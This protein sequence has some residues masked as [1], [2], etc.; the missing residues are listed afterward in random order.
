[1]YKSLGGLKE[2][3][4]NHMLEI[5][6]KIMLGIY[7]MILFYLTLAGRKQVDPLIN[8]FGG[9]LPFKRSNQTWNIDA[10]Y[11]I[12][13]LTPLT[14]F[15]GKSFPHITKKNLFKK[16]ILISF[17][18]SF[19][20]EINQLIFAIGTFQVSDLV[21]NTISGVIG[22][23][24]YKMSYKITSEQEKTSLIIELKNCVLYNND[25]HEINEVILIENHGGRALIYFKEFGPQIENADPIKFVYAIEIGLI[26]TVVRFRTDNLVYKDLLPD[27]VLINYY[28]ET[29]NYDIQEKYTITE[30]DISRIRHWYN[31]IIEWNKN[32]KA[33][34]RNLYWDMAYNR[35]LL[36]AR[37]EYIE[38][39]FLN[40]GLVLECLLN[41]DGKKISAKLRKYAASLC[42]S[43]QEEFENI[44]YAVKRGYDYR[45]KVVHG[46][47]EI[48]AEIFNNELIYQIYFELR[49]IVNKLMLI[50]YGKTKEEVIEQAKILLENYDIPSSN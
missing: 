38:N 41:I 11:N 32:W 33:G 29:D 24:I 19:F 3:Y 47:A 18:I 30:E 31:I 25:V 4:Q 39:R 13:L 35:Y 42:A 44:F 17:G 9:W 8:V 50:M 28:G 21:Y 26:D 7:I 43:N 15:L 22:G 48:V 45:C 40:M 49:R 1:M 36:D 10:L 5:V 12:F 6:W 14:F 2:K 16:M 34:Q 23:V 46:N 20:I 37:D 27:N